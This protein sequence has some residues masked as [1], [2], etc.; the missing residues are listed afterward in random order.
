[1]FV[2]RVWRDS[3]RYVCTEGVDSL[4]C[5][6]RECGESGLF[7]H[8][9]REISMFVHGEREITGGRARLL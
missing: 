6:Y 2:Q 9:E 3:P 4:V 5:L 7:V 8:K 1:M